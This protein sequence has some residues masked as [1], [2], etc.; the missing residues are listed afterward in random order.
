MC[1]GQFHGEGV[2][3]FEGGHMYKVEFTCCIT[4]LKSAFLTI[5]SQVSLKVNVLHFK[6]MFS[7]GFMDGPGVFTNADGLKYEVLWDIVM[8]FS[9]VLRRAIDLPHV[10]LKVC[11]VQCI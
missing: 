1:A 6:G 2:A 7:K 10:Y 3:Y 11:H 4:C 8:S 5:Y 9:F